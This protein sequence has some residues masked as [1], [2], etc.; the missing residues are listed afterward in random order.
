M[1]KFVLH[2]LRTAGER[3]TAPPNDSPPKPPDATYRIYTKEFDV[4]TNGAELANSDRRKAPEYVTNPYATIDLVAFERMVERLRAACSELSA[5]LQQTLA[6]EQRDDTVIALLFDHSGSLRPH[7]CYLTIAEVAEGLADALT[8]AGIATEILGFTTSRW[9]GGQAFEKWLKAGRP[10]LPGRLN[11]LLHIVYLDASGGPR[12]GP[13]RFPTM[14]DERRYKENIDGEALEW[15]VARLLQNTRSRKVL[16]V[17]SDGAPVDDATLT[18]N[19]PTILSD[20]A[21]EVADRIASTTNVVLGGIGIEHRVH[22]YYPNNAVAKPI[23]QLARVAPAFIE[24]M[25][26]LAHKSSISKH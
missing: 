19:W 11:D 4:V 20:H 12:R 7:A 8:S 21:K 23:E 3:F 26:A 22:F 17:V 1:L 10:S 24:D 16:I 6:P 25:I 5:R 13:H 18:Y 2:Y 14:R 9:K 15:A